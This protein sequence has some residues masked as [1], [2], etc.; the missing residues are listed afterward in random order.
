MVKLL[1]NKR[2]YYLDKKE[3]DLRE[4]DVSDITDMWAMFSDCENL[5][6]LN[7]SN[8][9]TKSAISMNRM[10]RNCK[11]LTKLNLSN[12]NTFEVITMYE[13]FE[14]CSS[15]TF[16]DIRI[17]NTSN[18]ANFSSMFSNCSSLEVL[19]LSNFD[20][21]N[22]K[23]TECMFLGCNSLTDLRF[24]QSLKNSLNL[25]DCPLTHESALSVINGLAEM[26]IGEC[27]FVTFN[28]KTY[29]T[30]TDDDIDMAMDKGWEIYSK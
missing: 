13:M 20:F 4:Y 30:L 22:A 7:I 12:F 2:F 9:C 8:W 25:S 18:V 6:N 17:F 11:S 3:L 23:H 16:L 1:P 5:T 19:D 15:L 28:E 26:N 14:N 10:F 21:S 27:K 24:G 29:D